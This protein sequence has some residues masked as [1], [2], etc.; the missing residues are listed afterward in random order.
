MYI[1]ED[2][3]LEGKQIT[4]LNQQDGKLLWQVKHFYALALLPQGNT[5]LLDAMEPSANLRLQN[6]NG[7]T[8]WKESYPL[9]EVGTDG[10]LTFNNY[11][12]AYI[13][14]QRSGS[15]R[16][17]AINLNN[18]RQLWK[19]QRTDISRVI[20]QNSQFSYAASFIEYD[21]QISDVK[22]KLPEDMVFTLSA[23]SGQLIA[24]KARDGSEVWHHTLE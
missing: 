4:A 5:L 7:Q 11:D 9:S 1:Q 19:S 18:G 13:I 16:L 17:L 3:N 10:V 20:D 24:L 22:D 2:S 6:A 12:T 21:P 23:S 15:G 8:L 14:T